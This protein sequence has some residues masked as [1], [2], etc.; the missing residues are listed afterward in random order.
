MTENNKWMSELFLQDF[1]DATKGMQ[2][3]EYMDLMELSGPER[4]KRVVEILKEQEE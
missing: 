2:G 4:L 1:M 3:Q